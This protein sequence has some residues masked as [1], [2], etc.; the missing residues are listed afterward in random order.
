MN[1][2]TL[3][4][5]NRVKKMLAL[6]NDNAASPGERDNAMRMAYNTLAKYNLSMAQVNVLDSNRTD[7][8]IHVMLDLYADTVWA[9]RACRGIATLFMCYHFRNSVGDS[10]RHSFVGKTVNVTTASYMAE[11]VLNSIIRESEK[12]TKNYFGE[13][14]LDKLLDLD[15]GETPEATKK[16]WEESFRVGAADA[17]YVR[18]E[19]MA[20]DAQSNN[21]QGEGTSLVLA[22]IYATELD[23]NSLFIKE[24]LGIHLTSLRKK[25][26]ER[27]QGA[28]SKGAVFGNSINLN[29][30]IS[31]GSSTLRIGGKK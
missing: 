22:S 19:K 23:A 28:A 24:N 26:T 4:I 15:T 30:Q 21:E 31:S 9:R 16:I 10:H 27:A 18:C 29:R 20:R 6:A 3:N 12:A 13:F 1:P 14:K 25:T 2:E 7:P 17:I 8:R 11:Y 5:L